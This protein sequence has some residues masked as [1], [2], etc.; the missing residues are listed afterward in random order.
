MISICNLFYIA[1][2]CSKFCSTRVLFIL[3]FLG[4]MSC[5]QSKL[6]EAETV[7]ARNR[8][9]L[10]ANQSAIT[11]DFKFKFET[12]KYLCLISYSNECS[13]SKSYIHTIQ[14]LYGMFGDTVAFCLLNPGLESK[15][16]TGMENCVFNDQQLAICRRYNVK[17][18]PQVVL[19]NCAQRKVLYSG[20]ID[21]RAVELGAVRIAAK[22]HYLKDAL[23]QLVEKG[24]VDI[25][26]NEAVGCFVDDF[27]LKP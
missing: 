11:D 19:V 13:V 25:Q 24:S 22:N 2:N 16:I 14:S 3:S 5:N 20:K 1:K 4:F 15:P 10:L 23:A 9:K 17:V 21:D 26:N 6:S 12:R 7:D 27:G 18:Y 8:T